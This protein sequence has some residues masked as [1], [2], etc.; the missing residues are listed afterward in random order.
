MSCCVFPP[1]IDTQFDARYADRRLERYRRKG[2]EG[3]TRRLLAAISDAGAG[4]ATV[5]D[6]GGGVGALACELIA[7]GARHA[8]VVEASKASL[9]AARAEGLRRRAGA[10]LALIHGDFV[11]MS[12]NVD[13]ADIVT[14]DKVVCC[15]PD[16]QSL[17]DRSVAHARRLYGI[18]YPRDVWWNRLLIAA[19]NALRRLRGSGFRAYVHSAREMERRI[20][21]AGLAL[22]RR[23]RGLIW[24]T[25]LYERRTTAA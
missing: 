14:L 11:A 25:D 18:T 7:E 5:L 4:G 10:R 1:D 21:T 16:M 2:V 15:F 6:I 20:V 13:S 3:T 24:V 9:D 17:I 19:Q 12:S 23:R 8:T 22:R